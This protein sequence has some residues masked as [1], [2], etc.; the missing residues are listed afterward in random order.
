[1]AYLRPIRTIIIK[2]LLMTSKW[3]IK[4][5]THLSQEAAILKL[6]KTHL[7]AKKRV[8]RAPYPSFP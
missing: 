3:Q 8:K 7:S 6:T 2:P 5:G 4:G 1:M